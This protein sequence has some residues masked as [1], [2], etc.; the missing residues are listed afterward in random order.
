MR[1]H[2]LIGV[3]LG[4]ALLA[5]ALAGSPAR[6]QVQVTP[7]GGQVKVSQTQRV[8]DLVVSLGRDSGEWAAGQN[9][10]IVE[11]RL[12]KDG[13]LV[14]AGHV[15]LSHSPT[16]PGV[17]L[18]ADKTPGRYLGTIALPDAGRRTV[19]VLWDGPAG[20]GSAKFSVSVR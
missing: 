4:S 9:A 13:Q 19:T 15:T 20:K 14:D 10:V 17:T 5:L 12:A 3:L 6:A 1:R 8:N 11:F 18:S 7:G 2:R 16:T